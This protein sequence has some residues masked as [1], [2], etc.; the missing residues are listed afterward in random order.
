VFWIS[1]FIAFTI[2]YRMPLLG[3]LP[4]I[5]TLHAKLCSQMSIVS[6]T[7]YC[8]ANSTLFQFDLSRPNSA[9]FPALL[10]APVSTASLASFVVSREQVL[11]VRTKEDI[12]YRVSSDRKT[13]DARAWPVGLL[14]FGPSFYN[15]PTNR[16]MLQTRNNSFLFWIGM[17]SF[18]SQVREKHS[19]ISFL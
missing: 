9:F 2:R 18:W 4:E 5:V 17:E 3:G 6:L 15:E 1:F 16:L 7:L 14:R 11:F 13:V 10:P 19:R 12:L 8:N